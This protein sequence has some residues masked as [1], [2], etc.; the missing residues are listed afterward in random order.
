[1]TGPLIDV[2]GLQELLASG[3][4]AVLLDVRW[5]LGSTDGNKQYQRGH[6]PG[7]V[8]ADLETDLAAP[9]GKGTEGRHPLPDPQDFAQTA[10][11]WGISRGDTVVAYDAVGGTSAARA[12]WLLR[13]AGLDSVYLLDGGIVAWH[14]AGL[15][16]EGGSVEPPPGDVELSW[17]KMPVV[18]MWDVPAV[19]AGGKLLDAR[20]KERYRGD[21]E[22][23][24]PLAGHIPGAVNAPSASNLTED[25]TFRAPEDLRASFEALGVRR[26]AP[27]AVYCGSGVTAAHE[28]AALELAGYRAALYPGSWSQWSATKG[29]PVAVGQKPGEWP[30]TGQRR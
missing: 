25:G 8:Y 1:M 18:Q 21:R 11:N 26:N 23:V 30:G 16:L 15:A 24:D 20:A 7:A 10:R 17:G 12:W 4:G 28:V 9:A 22:P 3:T 29:S 27:V 13:H 6:I 2:A 14:R 19:V 5:E